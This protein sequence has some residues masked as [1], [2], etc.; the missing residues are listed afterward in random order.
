MHILI[1]GASGHVGT[2]L[3]QHLSADHRI[4]GIVRSQPES[5]TAYEPVV[6]PDWVDRP[7]AVIDELHRLD[8]SSVDAVIAAVGGWYVDISMIARGIASFDEDYSSYL[9]GHFAACAVSEALA[10]AAGS[11]HVRH[12]ALNGVASVEA[13]VGSG[14]I[15]VFGAAQEM[16]I[17][18]AEAE[19]D[20]VDYRE[21]KVMAP[22]GGDDRND[23]RG[24]VETISLP[25]VAEAVSAV[26]T[27]PDE[28]EISTQLGV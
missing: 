25:Q 14:A 2:G 15:S 19:T 23:L 27:R 20:S 6:V 17:R 13:C 12:L 28:H 9:R 11:A 8:A 1:F 18:V 26:L 24:G 10:E 7:Q 22:I 4:T 16:L 3:A 21:L 5:T